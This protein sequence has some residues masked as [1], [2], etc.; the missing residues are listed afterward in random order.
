MTGESRRSRDPTLIRIVGGLPGVPTHAEV[1][2]EQIN[3]RADELLPPFEARAL[4]T[5]K[6]ARARFATIGG[7][8]NDV[9]AEGESYVR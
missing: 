2:G 4:T 5:A 6:A 3:R 7:L 1:N 9:T 8:L